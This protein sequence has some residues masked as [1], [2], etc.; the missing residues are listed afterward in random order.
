MGFAG[1]TTQSRRLRREPNSHNAAKPRGA[2][3]RL[4]S[5]HEFP[6][7][8]GWT[9]LH[10]IS[11]EWQARQSLVRLALANGSND[12]EPPCHIDP[13]HCVASTVV[14]SVRR[15]AAAK[16]GASSQGQLVRRLQ[17]VAC[18]ARRRGARSTCGGPQGVTWPWQAQRLLSSGAVLP[19][20]SLKLSPNG[21][22]PGPGRRY[23]AHFRQP[24]PGVPPSVPT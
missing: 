11:A 12:M 13:A 21:G 3:A 14:Q 16:D 23:P 9:E 17:T 18:H 7:G 2:S 22:P 5:G 15:A 20:P 6:V 4:R 1:P 8:C 19:N 10:S 24:G